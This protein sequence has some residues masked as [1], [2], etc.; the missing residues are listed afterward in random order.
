M[1]VAQ[2]GVGTKPAPVL[3]ALRNGPGINH[4][5]GVWD[6]A[7]IARMASSGRQRMG[8]FRDVRSLLHQRFGR[9]DRMAQILDRGG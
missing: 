4:G 5:R 9:Q 2:P 7:E 1:L 8:D 3:A 6:G